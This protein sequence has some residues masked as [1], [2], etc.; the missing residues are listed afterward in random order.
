MGNT[1][2]LSAQA[3]PQENIKCIEEFVKSNQGLFVVKPPSMAIKNLK[4]VENN[5]NN[6]GTTMALKDYKIAKF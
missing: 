2:G 5:R 4:M 3:S 6:K 1:Q